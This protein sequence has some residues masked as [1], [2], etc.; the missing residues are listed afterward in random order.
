MG[1]VFE[2][3][4]A[5]VLYQIIESGVWKLRSDKRQHPGIA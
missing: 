2:N 3:L 1:I 5:G 4:L